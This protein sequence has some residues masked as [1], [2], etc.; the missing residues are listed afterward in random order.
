MSFILVL[1]VIVVLRMLTRAF[2]HWYNPEQQHWDDVFG[3]NRWR[4]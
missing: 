2:N 3:H 4:K 1:V